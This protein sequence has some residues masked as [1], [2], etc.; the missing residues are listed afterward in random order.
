[1]VMTLSLQKMKERKNMRRLR[2]CLGAKTEDKLLGRV[3]KRKETR[4]EGKEKKEKKAEKISVLAEAS[5]PCL[6]REVTRG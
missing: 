4:R 1:M 6:A 3:K 2:T 5:K